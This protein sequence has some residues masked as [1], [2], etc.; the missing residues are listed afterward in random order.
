MTLLGGFVWQ[1]YY[2]YEKLC[3]NLI[4]FNLILF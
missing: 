2:F 4:K 1:A 3:L